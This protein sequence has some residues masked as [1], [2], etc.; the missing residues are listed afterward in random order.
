MSKL[1]VFIIL[2]AL[3]LF[4]PGTLLSDD[5]QEGVPLSGHYAGKPL[6]EAPPAA[7]E[8]AE[9]GSARAALEYGDLPVIEKGLADKIAGMSPS[10]MVRVIIALK[11]QPQNVIARQVQANH[12]A[13]IAEIET[14]IKAINDRAME[15]RKI[16]TGRDADNYQSGSL[17]PTA[18]EKEALDAISEKNEA[19]SLVIKNETTALL[20][21]VIKNDQEEVLTAI[22]NQG[23]VVEFTTICFN[24]VI[25]SVPVSALDRIAALD[26][27]SR[28]IED[29]LLDGNLTIADD[30]TRVSDT[31]GLWDNGQDGGLYDPAI[32]DSGT[33]LDH[34][35]LED[36]ADRSNF[37][38]WYLVAGVADPIWDDVVSEDD[39]NGHGTH[40]MGIV[41]SYGTPLY[42]NHL[43]MAYGVEKAVTLKAGWNGTDGRAHM[44]H[45]D[46]MNLVDRALYDTNNLQPNSTFNDDVDGMNLSYSGETTSDETDYS[47][48]WDSVVSTYSDLVVTLSAGNSG[49]SNT[50]FRSPACA[51]NPITVANVD[52][53]DTATRTDDIIRYSST[54]GP[55]ANGRRKPD[56]AAPGTDIDS[57]NNRWETETD[58]IEKSGTS[59]AAP[60]VLGVA[61]DLMDAGVVD[62]MKVKALLINTAQKNEGLIDFESDTDG[63]SEAYGWGYMNA[64]AAYYHRGDV[65]SDTVTERPNAGYYHLYKGQLRDEGAIGEGRDRVTMAWNRHAT[66]DPAAY[67]TTYYY[68]SD[69]NLRL[70]RESDEVL[71][72]SDLDGVDNVHQVRIDSGAGDT[73]V[74]VK[75]YSWATSF[76]HGGSTETFAL[77]T[78]ENFVEVDLPADFQA[79]GLWPSEMEPNEEADFTFWIVNNSDIASHDNEFDLSLPSGWSLVSGSDPYDAGSIAGTGGSSSSV[80]WTLRAGS[81]IGSTNVTSV[82]SH[83]SYLE[84]W[85]PYNWWMGVD[86]Q[87]DTTPPS[88]DPMTWDIT[89]YAISNSQISMTATTAYDIH[90]PVEYYFDYYNSPTGGG[91]GT[92]SGWQT[93]IS[94]TDSGLGVNH[95]YSYRVKARDA[96]TTPNETGYSGLRYIY[97]FANTPAAPTVDNPTVSTL[98][99]TINANGNPGHT[100]C[101]IWLEEVSS[102]TGY[103][104]NTSGGSSGG[105]PVW[106]TISTW[107]T[108]TATG[109]SS[110]TQ[111][112][113]EVK[114]RN[115]D[116][117]ETS[118]SPKGYG[119]TTSASFT[120]TI[121]PNPLVGGSPG[122]FDITNG[123]PNTAT[124]LVYS[125]VGPGSVWVAP[126]NVTIDLA[127]PQLAFGP[128]NTNGSG[129]V[130]W[131]VPIPS[132]GSG[133]SVWF[134]GVQYGQTTNVVSMTIL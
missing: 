4:C 46:A 112:S 129:A 29:K 76:A 48:F 25:A 2:T 45:S 86:V 63:W 119:T 108:V 22:E 117:I 99:I 103:Y 26:K 9:D 90:D 56:I 17:K 65:I 80:T 24:A 64:L 85:G 95:Q 104:L 40:V 6:P 88:P 33:D 71:I 57:C 16:S 34:P 42:P 23:G 68:L 83:D 36:S 41:G 98:D 78:E 100:E 92:N 39:V 116:G 118:W 18:E 115:G 31:N 27:V 70:Y 5:F 11:Y 106:A 123:T 133:L 75:A 73:D 113:A 101:A 49:P 59:M 38:S 28:L 62:E 35:A 131:N 124:Y 107:G 110:G 130:S 43:G 44:Y 53:A 114:A 54:R 67:P 105:T 96:A 102:G 109:L 69:L 97:T 82:H 127:N 89:P 32:L 10:E 128:T 20:S 66:Y 47:R 111:Y 81:T 7:S 125:L 61:M 91:G 15:A 74:I 121:T 21:A 79:Y 12:A 58:F 87:W 94:Y 8:G 126:L 52:D 55:T 93:S 122:A 72:D 1:P 3:L 132:G 13:E 134:Q 14:T 37:Y 19:L 77:A 50:Y 51:Y 60:M 84:A 30:A 120:L